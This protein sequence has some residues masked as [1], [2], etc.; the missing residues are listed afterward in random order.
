MGQEPVMKPTLHI[1]KSAVYRFAISLVAV[2]GF[3]A[4]QDQTPHAWRSVN[5]PLPA[6][7]DQAPAQREQSI[8]LNG[9]PDQSQAGDPQGNQAPPSYNGPGPNY[10]PAAN[11]GVPPKLTI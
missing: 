7:L 10:P 1:T 9:Q 5:D 3:A 11:F 4:A 2:A 8:N 6:G